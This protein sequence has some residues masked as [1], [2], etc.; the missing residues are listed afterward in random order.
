M[1]NAPMIASL[2]TILDR[3][4]I[5]AALAFLN[6]QTP[7]RFTALY[8]FDDDMLKNLYFYD[9]QHPDVDSSAEIPVNASY[10][11]FVRQ[12]GMTWRVSD[13]PNDERADGHPKQREVRSY[14]GVPLLDRFGKLFGTICHFDFEA[15]PITNSNVDLLEAVGP[16]MSEKLT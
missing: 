5:R 9:R 15:L 7:H 12:S 3:D 2:K 8:R 4:G 11:V 6:G 14:C 13:A 1:S 16:L 10:C